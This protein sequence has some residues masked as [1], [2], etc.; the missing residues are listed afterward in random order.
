MR[1]S[2]CGSQENIEVF[3]AAPGCAVLGLRLHNGRTLDFCRATTPN[4][5]YQILLCGL[6]RQQKLASQG[7]VWTLSVSLR[8]SW[9]CGRASPNSGWVGIE[10]CL[11]PEEGA[12][13]HDSYESSRVQLNRNVNWRR[14]KISFLLPRLRPRKM[15]AVYWLADGSGNDEVQSRNFVGQGLMKL[16]SILLDWSSWFSKASPLRC[17]FLAYCMY[18]YILKMHSIS[19]ARPRIRVHFC[20]ACRGWPRDGLAVWP[21]KVIWVGCKWKSCATLL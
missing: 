14:C 6:G 17:V 11:N 12:T 8:L 16:D 18:A 13:G 20:S 5:V 10:A 4:H 3:K 2:L 9:H 1:R 15:W 21:L 19:S 7:Y